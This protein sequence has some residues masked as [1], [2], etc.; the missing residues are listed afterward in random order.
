MLSYRC[1]IAEARLD[2]L[3]KCPYQMS[4]HRPRSTDERFE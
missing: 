2:P 1:P 3:I 4:V